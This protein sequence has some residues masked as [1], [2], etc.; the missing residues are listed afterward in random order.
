MIWKADKG[1]I[2]YS[3]YKN[4]TEEVYGS[5]FVILMLQM[6]YS[7]IDEGKS[8]VELLKFVII[9]CIGHICI[10]IASAGHAYYIRLKKTK[11]YSY[12]FKK[13][14]EKSTH[15][16]LA[17]FEE[18]KFYD[19]F[20]KALDEC[21]TKAIDGMLEFA[22]SIG[23]MLAA[24][25]SAIIIVRVDPI[26]ILFAIPPILAMQF[27]GVKINELSLELRNLETREKRA[28]EYV[29]RVF[30]EKK[31]ASELRLYQIKK[32]LLREQKKSFEKRT[33]I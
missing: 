26:L 27:F 10:H 29:K 12:F 8:F 1:C 7:Y 25:T 5:F 32:V 24:I 14:I 16:P 19:D 17:K 3:F 11:V 2:I 6:I 4:C 13:V 21:F 31:Y 23:Y 20:A 28:S 18:P 30:Y 9:F 15:I 22:G 33:N